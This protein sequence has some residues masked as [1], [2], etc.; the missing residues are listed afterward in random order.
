MLAQAQESECCGCEE[1]DLR[2]LRDRQY[3]EAAARLLGRRRMATPVRVRRNLPPWSGVG[4]AV[5]ASERV[6]VG[7]RGVWHKGTGNTLRNSGLWNM[8]TMHVKMS[9]LLC[10]CR[11]RSSGQARQGWLRAVFQSVV[12]GES[13]QGSWYALG[14]GG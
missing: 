14:A 7:A 11:R 13:R 8:Q 5:R 12:P 10:V 9:G 4:D 3:G 6:P 2:L 1:A